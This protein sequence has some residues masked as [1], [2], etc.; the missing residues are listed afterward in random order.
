MF[1]V[2]WGRSVQTYRGVTVPYLPWLVVGFAVWWYIRPCI[3]DGCSAVFAKTNV[4]TK[5][6]FPVSV[7]PATVCLKELFNHFVMLVITFVTLFLSGYMPNIY[8]LWIVYYMFCAFMLGEAISLVLSV[9][10][11]LWRD[12]KKFITS[13]MRML[14][15]FSPI[16]WN[17]HFKKSVP[18]SFCFKQACEGQPGLLCDSRVSGC[19]F[20]SSYTFQ[21]PSYYPIFL[22]FS[23]SDFCVGLFLDVYLQEEIHRYDLGGLYGRRICSR[24]RKYFENLYLTK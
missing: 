20:L 19:D 23:L 5:M 13:I 21:S 6:K 4:I 2:A 14:M 22:G 12:V 18:F 17:C 15:Y 1:G 16:L 3:T 7:L 10:T 11:M 24:S 9:L 8:W